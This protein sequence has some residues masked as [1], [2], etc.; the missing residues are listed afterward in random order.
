[1]RQGNIDG[2]IPG[3]GALT[4]VGASAD[5][6][7]PETVRLGLSQDVGS[8]WAF[9]FGAAWR[10][11]SRIEE[12]RVN[13]TTPVAPLAGA[14]TI[15]TNADWKNTWFLSAGAA[16]KPTENLILRTGIG[17]DESPVPDAT[18]GPGIPG[19]DGSAITFGATYKV[20]DYVEIGATY[21]HVFQQNA[22]V[23]LTNPATGNIS[24]R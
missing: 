11:W 4:V 20:N 24:E 13:F 23:S 8:Q 15:A 16:Y 18:R 3:I 14:T 21:V 5:L 7:L 17:F 2:I 12:Q 22:T 9:H 1:M 19:T 10:R 6:N